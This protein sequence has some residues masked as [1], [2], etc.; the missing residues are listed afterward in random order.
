MVIYIAVPIFV[1]IYTYTYKIYKQQLS[2][3]LYKYK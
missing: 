1:Y 3:D 2:N